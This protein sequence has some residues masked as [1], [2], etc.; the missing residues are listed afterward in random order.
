LNP[1]HGYQPAQLDALGRIFI[2]GPCSKPQEEVSHILFIFTTTA[3]RPSKGQKK[4]KASENHQIQAKG[5]A[6]KREGMA[7]SKN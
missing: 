3:K 5:E 1:Q 7:L 2:G 4:E 6:N